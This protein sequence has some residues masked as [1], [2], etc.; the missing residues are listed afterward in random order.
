MSYDG[1]VIAAGA[2]EREDNPLGSVFIFKR[3]GLLNTYRRVGDKLVG[4][5]WETRGCKYSRSTGCIVLLRYKSKIESSSKRHL[6]LSKA[7]S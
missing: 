7:F 2:I 3:G 6:T 5:G 1:S 4:T